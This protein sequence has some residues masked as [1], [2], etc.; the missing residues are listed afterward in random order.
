MPATMMKGSIPMEIKKVRI[1]AKRQITIPQKFL[2]C[3]GLK[4]KQNVWYEGMNW[5]FVLQRQTQVGNLQNRY[6]RI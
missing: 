5:L 1:S 6:W 4:R 3:W 2:Q